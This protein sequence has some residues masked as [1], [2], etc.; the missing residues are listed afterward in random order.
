MFA[1]GT[2]AQ[3]TLPPD[4]RP[5][6]PATLAPLRAVSGTFWRGR[7][8][9]R[10]LLVLIP[11]ALACALIYKMLSGQWLNFYPSTYAPWSLAGS[12]LFP[13]SIFQIPHQVLILGL[14]LSLLI[15]LP[16]FAAQIFGVAP[17]AFFV[18]CVFWLGHLPILALFLAGAVVLAGTP[19]LLKRSRFYA[20]LLAL[21]PLVIYLFLAV[22]IVQAWSGAAYAPAPGPTQSLLVRLLTYLVSPTALYL[23][24]PLF[25]LLLFLAG[26]PS[27]LRRTRFYSLV[28]LAVIIAAYLAVS[29]FVLAQPGQYPSAAPVCSAAELVW[30]EMALAARDSRVALVNL[31]PI[32]QSWL[33]APALL[34]VC[35]AL[36]L[37]PL[38]LLLSRWSKRPSAVLAWATTAIILLSLLLFYPLVGPETLDYAILRARF[39]PASALLRDF[40]DLPEYNRSL[41]QYRLATDPA[42][43]AAL[44]R[45]IR[46]ILY[47]IVD[48]FEQRV[49]VAERACRHF[50]E[51]YPRSRHKPHVLYM[52]ALVQDA[53]LDRQR[54]A[55]HGR[56]W[57]YYNCPSPQSKAVLQQLLEEFPDNV[58]ACPGGLQLGRLL[59]REGCFDAALAVLDQAQRSGRTFLDAQSTPNSAQTFS[60][61][62]GLPPAE[63]ISSQQIPSSL[64]RTAQLIELIRTSYRDPLYGSEPLR[65]FCTKDP[66]SPDYVQQIEAIL[67]EFPDAL[68]ADHIRLQIILAQPPAQQL[69]LL[70]SAIAQF[71][72]GSAAK[73]ALFHLAQ[74]EIALAGS[75]PQKAQLRRRAAEH[76][77]RFLD[78]YPQA[79]QL[80]LVKDQLDR[81]DL[82]AL[83]THE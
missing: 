30:P 28:L 26:L 8:L 61:R 5:T 82:L 46:R 83:P 76:F 69:Y 60:S 22:Q 57:V 7:N 36:F 52:K 17:A 15:I 72:A 11:F 25:M 64:R 63:L 38:L 71:T 65:R 58:L 2:Q 3:S 51:D 16:I 45:L 74:L 77:R 42:R 75:D 44:R 73:D 41:E 21:V 55:R 78:K 66:L 62:I 35:L 33:Y 47:H 20:G 81:L 18:A 80:Q 23:L 48:E 39:E 24:G 14:L 40:P 49:T 56:I 6:K 70:E 31:S 12:F 34:A 19:P 10:F 13:L 54:L 27:L 79:Y 32:Q 53:R 4:R 37:L 9:R 68:V 1:V 50:L 29:V 59:A 43:S 67:A